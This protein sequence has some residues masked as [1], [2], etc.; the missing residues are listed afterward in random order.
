MIIKFLSG[1]KEN[2]PTLGIK[3]PLK[4]LLDIII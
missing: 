4:F 2:K 3:K 1:R